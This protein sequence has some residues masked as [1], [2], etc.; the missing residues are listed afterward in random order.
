MKRKIS[1]II[2]VT[3][4][5]VSISSVVQI[6][7]VFADASKTYD[8]VTMQADAAPIILDVSDEIKNSNYVVATMNIKSYGHRKPNTCIATGIGIATKGRTINDMYGF[9]MAFDHTSYEYLVSD[10]AG[11]SAGYDWQNWY[12]Y[13]HYSNHATPENMKGIFEKN[14]LNIKLVRLDQT[15]FLLAEYKN[16]WHQIGYIVLPEN[17]KTEI[18]FFNLKN[19]T[20]YSDIE[21]ETGKTSVVKALGNLTI[22]VNSEYSQFQ[23]ML[24]DSDWSV[25]MKI[26]NKTPNKNNM[27]DIARLTSL[28]GKANDP[29]KEYLTIEYQADVYR[30]IHYAQ[31]PMYDQ[32]FWDTVNTLPDTFISALSNEGLYARFVRN[33]NRLYILL[34]VDGKNYTVAES[35]KSSNLSPDPQMI[36]IDLNDRYLYENIYINI[37]EQAIVDSLLTNISIANRSEPVTLDISDEIQNSEYIVAS[38]NIRGEKSNVSGGQGVGL[39]IASKGNA[40]SDVYGFDIMVGLD[41]LPHYIADNSSLSTAH[42]PTNWYYFTHGDLHP[43][44]DK[45]DAIFT[46]DGLNVKLV[47]LGRTVFLLGEYDGDWNQL[48]Y[49]VLPK[50]QKTSLNFFSMGVRSINYRNIKLE[51]GKE[52]AESNLNGL[53]I[54]P[55]ETFSGN[56][57]AYNMFQYDVSDFDWKVDV[58][59]TDKTPLTDETGTI[60][61]IVSATGN[62][63]DLLHRC[64]TLEYQAGV[65]RVV[66]YSQT[67]GWTWGENFTLE[68]DYVNALKSDGLYIRYIRN[69]SDLYLMLSKDGVTYNI[70]K[71]FDNVFT[72]DRGLITFEIHPQ[73]KYEK[74][75]LTSGESN[76]ISTLVK[77]VQLKTL[78]HRTEYIEEEKFDPTGLTVEVSYIGG[79]KPNYIANYNECSYSD[80]ELTL[81]T[82]KVLGY[83]LNFKFEIEISVKEKTIERVELI[84]K[85]KKILYR[86]NETLNVSGGRVKL[87]YDNGKSE[88]VEI[89]KNMCSGYE[90]KKSGWQKVL[91]S[92]TKNGTTKSDYYEILLTNSD[93]VNISFKEKPSIIEFNMNGSFCVDGIIS[94]NFADGNYFEMDITKEICSNYNL[95]VAGM[96]EVIVAVR[97]KSISYVIKVNEKSAFSIELISMPTKTMYRL[98]EK[99]D[100]SGAIISVTYNDMSHAEVL[101]RPEFVYGFNNSRIGRDDLT[102]SYGGQLIEFPIDMKA[103]AYSDSNNQNGNLPQKSDNDI[104]KS[105]RKSPL[106]GDR[107][108]V[109][110]SFLALL[111]SCFV[112]IV[113]IVLKRKQK[114]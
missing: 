27:G 94:L 56:G 111:T 70:V 81:G 72:G 29:W 98:G 49:I 42:D 30:T 6:S 60:A 110:E 74:F 8:D 97:N 14:G 15:V 112:L 5:L 3:M 36:S 48:S 62:P 16:I 86:L 31:R 88:E 4:V 44:Q 84:E 104:G 101:V 100:M 67:P 38:M 25:D 1:I 77:N 105:S 91:V 75:S 68:N 41:W 90:K 37:G 64:V 7:S 17:T 10:N 63:N 51:I 28:S 46:E 78:P 71:V 57:W 73:Y 20:H 114:V 33:G 21:I 35:V 34:S 19:K 79:I 32:I 24:G 95:E 99:L 87:S 106:T 109:A 53:T 55:D 89:T 92:Y 40:I 11:N 54:V 13:A 52:K 50:E 12:H 82:N 103:N 113:T 96:Q 23:Y 39:G 107:A 2:A 47:R 66:Q 108:M 69:K 22:D 43:T 58:K 65:Y 45:I 93:V 83:Y 61:R 59:I 76:T 85:P 18:N 9:Y 102:I 80:N 26:K